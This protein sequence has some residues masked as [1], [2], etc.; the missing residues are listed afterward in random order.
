MTSF[1]QNKYKCAILTT[2]VSITLSTT[3]FFQSHKTFFSKKVN[4]KFLMLPR[5]KNI[6]KM[7]QHFKG[8]LC[9]LFCPPKKRNM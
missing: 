2:A 4:A 6:V 7:Q 8:V 5:T 9:L 1:L 3:S